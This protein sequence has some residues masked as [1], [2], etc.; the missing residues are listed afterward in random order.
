MTLLF[1][2]ASVPVKFAEG[3]Y[4]DDQNL[5]RVS[6]GKLPHAVHFLGVVNE[7]LERQVV[8]EGL[9]VLRGDLDILQHTL[10]DGHAGHD[11]NELLEAVAE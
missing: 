2:S 4:I 1:C 11:D 10:A 8:V 5:N 3:V 9:E 7:M 6:N